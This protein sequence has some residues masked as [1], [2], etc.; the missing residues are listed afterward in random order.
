MK[1]LLTGAQGYLGSY[2][3]SELISYN[4]VKTLGR[5][6]C[7]YNIDLKNTN[8]LINEDFDCIIHC[9]GLA[10]VQPNGNFV[11][12]AKKFLDTNVLGTINLLS[13]FRDSKKLTNFI[14]ISSVSVYGVDNGEMLSEMQ[15][16][17][18]TEPYGYSKLLQELIV[19][20]WCVK[21]KVTLSIFRLPL[22][23][24]KNAPGNFGSLI[25]AIKSNSFF[26]VSGVLTRKSMVLAQDIAK[27]ILMSIDIGGVYNLTDG[28][29]PEI[30]Y[31]VN[32]IGARYKV[33]VISVPYF[34]L[35]LIAKIGDISL[36]LI[37]LNTYKFHKL[38]KSLT[39][40]DEKAQVKIGWNPKKVILNLNNILGSD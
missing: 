36:G 34:I 40:S 10:H 11:N 21:K 26:N 9:A 23:V 18:P 33:K 24:G 32:E 5:S 37:P 7:D 16:T 4:E 31:L 13:Q 22:V 19:T 3:Y 14:L 29:N 15:N 8:F 20:E 12:G 1:I 38:T 2:I 28:D 27:N 30:K 25:N 6:N 35:Y 39:F 17:N